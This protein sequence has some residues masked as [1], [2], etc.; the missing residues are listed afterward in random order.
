MGVALDH[1][2]SLAEDLGLVLSRVNPARQEWRI[3]WQDAIVMP[4][5]PVLATYISPPIN[6]IRSTLGHKSV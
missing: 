4:N 2:T 6:C 5:H 1:T 3:F